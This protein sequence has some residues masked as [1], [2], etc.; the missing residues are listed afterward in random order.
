[1]CAARLRAF[2]QQLAFKLFAK[3]TPCLHT[4]GRSKF[5]DALPHMLH[6]NHGPE[7]V[8]QKYLC[9]ASLLFT[10]HSRP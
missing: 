5:Q 4:E 1:M 10:G 8:A 3:P 7:A 2:T 6:K 9:G